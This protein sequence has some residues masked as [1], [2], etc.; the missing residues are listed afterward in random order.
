MNNCHV[1]HL[2]ETAST[3]TF[4]ASYTPPA[5]TDITI[6]TTDY[7]SAGRGQATNRWESER[8][9]NLLFSILVTPDSL[10][11]NHLF[12]LSEAIALGIRET[13]VTTLT[14]SAEASPLGDDARPV[15]V[16]WPNDIYI[17]DCKI[18]GILIE[19]NLRGQ[20][21]NRSIIGCGVNINQSS[22]L[23]P[24]LAPH[25]SSSSNIP[26]PVSLCQLLGRDIDRQAVLDAVIAHFLRRY[27][28][29]SNGQP[30][31]LAAIHAEYLDALYR[32]QGLHLFADAQ[33]SF[34]A[35]IAGVEPTGH[36]ILR[37]TSGCLRRY[38]F[39]EV[40]YC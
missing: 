17:G 24:S 35:E 7:Q 31:A 6:V 39:K 13:I 27:R 4:L 3:N 28:S 40:S 19:N 16:K 9:K 38:A 20:Y 21:V 36:L 22:F 5:P 8:S 37:D 34:R 25:A 33:G 30:D 32:R 2:T 18:A 15:T 1:I 11:A 10:P 12:A 29:I 26:H 23:F 14:S